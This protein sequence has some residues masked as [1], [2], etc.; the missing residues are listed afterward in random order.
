[1]NS[2]KKTFGVIKKAF[3][4]LVAILAIC[5][6]IFT[7]VSVS[8]FNRQDRSIFGYKGFIVLSDSMAA[9]DFKAGDLVISKE[10]APSEIK[11]GDIIT[12]I[13]SDPDSYGEVF[14]HKVRT[15]ENKNGNLSFIT[16]GTTTNVN[17][18]TP[19][20]EF[21][22]LGKYQFALP[23]VG[24]FFNFMKTTPGYI[25]CIFVPF[26]ILIVMQVID[27]ISLFKQYKQEQLQDIKR[28]KEE[29]QKQREENERVMKELA[30]IKAKLNVMDKKE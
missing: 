29:L 12:F 1:M 19:V 22:V 5:M 2:M 30:E 11:E 27:T 24:T 4:T 21:N 26:M 23:K 13:S 6:A 16:Y 17:D 18:A 14:T 9:T 20:S 8:T 15:V 10:I 28:E 25:C 3:T 7:V